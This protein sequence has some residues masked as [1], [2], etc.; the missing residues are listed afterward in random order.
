[1]ITR[2][3]LRIRDPFVYVENGVYYLLG[4]TG[5]DCWEHGSDLQL[6]ASH[7]LEGFEPIGCMVNPDAFDG[8]RNIWA[9]ELHR[10]RDKYYLIVSL[11]RDDIGRGSMIFV[12]D[13]L[14]EKFVPL[15]GTYITPA[16]WTCLDAT[17]FIWKDKPYLFFSNEWVQSVNRDGD[18]S[19]YAAELTE[20]LK[21]LVGEPQKVVSGKGSGFA[22]ELSTGRGDATGYIAEGPFVAEEDGKVCCYWSTVAKDGYCIAKSTASDVFAPYTFERMIFTKD[23]GHCMIFKNLSGE[24]MLTFHQPNVSPDERMKVFSIK[25]MEVTAL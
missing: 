6:Y 11:F 16:D 10:Y 5:G 9:P 8:Y 18:G 17:L 15:T 24:E 25:E 19:I 22:V 4:T 23:G 7:D 13:S 3:D 1:M 2:E 14:H 12:S 21:T 20:D